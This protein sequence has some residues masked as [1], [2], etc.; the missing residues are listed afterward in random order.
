MRSLGNLFFGLFWGGGLRPCVLVS[1]WCPLPPAETQGVL[2]G[3]GLLRVETPEAGACL[4][5]PLGSDS[6]NPA[7]DAARAKL[8]QFMGASSGAAP[9]AGSG[10]AAA[11]GQDGGENGGPL[12]VLTRLP[13]ILIIFAWRLALTLAVKLRAGG[14]AGGGASPAAAGVEG[15]PGA[16]GLSA[17]SGPLAAVGGGGGDS[18]GGGVLGLLSTA[19]ATWALAK[20]L[21]VDTCAALFSALGVLAIGRVARVGLAV[22]AGHCEPETPSL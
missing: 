6:G 3:L 15:A 18:G 13:I 11:P 2:L 21:V 20:D 5:S 22:S 10:A 1:S 4:P 17:C 8:E 14:L 16:N 19:M 9:P 7:A 12:A